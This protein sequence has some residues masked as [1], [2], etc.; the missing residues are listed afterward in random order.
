[1]NEAQKRRVAQAESIVSQFQHS[2]VSGEV[3]I[4]IE[5]QHAKVA[6]RGVQLKLRNIG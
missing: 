4:A 5:V 3:A 6:R 1:M 2:F